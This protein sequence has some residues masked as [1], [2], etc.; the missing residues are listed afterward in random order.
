MRLPLNR[1]T[2]HDPRDFMAISYDVAVAALAID[3]PLK[4]LDNLLSRHRIPGVEQARQGVTRRL[5]RDAL[6]T[7]ALVRLLCTDLGVPVE[8]AV[9]L[10]V[11]LCA[12]DD[13]MLLM[14][15]GTLTLAVDRAD[16]AQRIAARLPD[17]VESAPRR[18]RGR[19]PIRS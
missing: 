8:R 3:A 12:S 9:D 10:A 2:A 14:A 11:R 18:P 15:A 17:A 19:P 1:V 7:I 13:D 6:A 16:L 5:S 4:W